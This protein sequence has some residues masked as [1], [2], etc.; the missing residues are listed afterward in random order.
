MAALGVA[1][2]LG[3][4]GLAGCGAS[5]GSDGA[6][7]VFTSEVTVADAPSTTEAPPTTSTTEAT[8]STSIATGAELWVGTVWTAGTEDAQ[9][10][11]VDGADVGLTS[12]SGLCVDPECELSSDLLTAMPASA[13]GPRPGAY[14][15][16]ANRLVDRTGEGA[17]IWEVTD[18]LDVVLAE[19]E[20]PIL[21]SPI[22]DPSVLVQGV[23]SG[24][25]PEGRTVTPDRVWAVAADGAIA[26]PDP[27]GYTCD[28]GED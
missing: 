7:E 1:G 2:A 8:T 10:V 9:Q 19:G 18:A 5:G 20:V 3:V 23:A 15:V 13:D 24:E 17:P 28:V 27:A 22:D 6:G 11:Y 16:F 25:L 26:T 21:C 4:V 12:V 14:L